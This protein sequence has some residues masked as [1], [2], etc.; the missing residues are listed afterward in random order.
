MDK[1]PSDKCAHLRTRLGDAGELIE[2]VLV[3]YLTDSMVK[4]RV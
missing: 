3:G 2:V 4:V 1:L